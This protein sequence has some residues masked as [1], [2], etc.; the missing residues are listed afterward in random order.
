MNVGFYYMANAGG[1]LVGTLL[2]APLSSGG[3]SP[4]AWS[5]AFAFSRPPLSSLLLRDAVV[6]T[7]EG[8]VSTAAARRPTSG[9][10]TA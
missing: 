5:G 8:T 2:S 3:A 4:P 1:R 7:R 10:V 6:A 9:P